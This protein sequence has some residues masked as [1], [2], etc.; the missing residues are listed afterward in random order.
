M[1]KQ[2]TY[3][4]NDLKVERENLELLLG[5]AHN[6][7][8][9]PFPFMIDA[10]FQEAP[11]LF[12]IR[13]GYRLVEPVYFHKEGNRM[14][15]AG[16]FFSPGK[17]VFNQVRKAEKLVLFAGTAGEKISD[18]CR[19]LNQEGEAVYSYV[20]D[21][22]GS[23]VAGKAID[24]LADDLEKESAAQGYRISES[25]S[26]GYCDWSVAEQQQ[27]FSF[28]PLGFLGIRL[29][30]SSLMTPVKSVSG[31]IGIGPELK[32]EGYQCRLCDDMDCMFGKIRRESRIG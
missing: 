32:R 14:E 27:L 24:K 31:I 17:T 9:D 22:M 20:L 2:F 13:T 30:D 5:F 23:V 15:V 8:P 16:R 28:F 29:S 12:E 3:S 18:R 1:L 19:H 21:V 7:V 26:P 10:A 25:Y 11:G 4:Y 6:E